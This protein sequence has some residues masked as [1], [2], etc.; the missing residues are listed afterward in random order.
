MLPQTPQGFHPWT[1]LGDFR[2]QT[3][4]LPTPRKNTS[5]APG[6][7]VLPTVGANPRSGNASDADELLAAAAVL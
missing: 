3:P 1:L 7:A 6:A 4:N 2:P 5:G